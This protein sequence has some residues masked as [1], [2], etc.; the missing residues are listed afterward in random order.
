MWA[1]VLLGSQGGLRL[2]CKAHPLAPLDGV[3]GKIS[4][5]ANSPGGT[6]Q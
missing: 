2:F 4:H 3:V 1:R 5:A 6:S